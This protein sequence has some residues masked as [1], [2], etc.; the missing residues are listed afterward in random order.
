MLTQIIFHPHN[1]ILAGCV[2]NDETYEKLW[3]VRQYCPSIDWMASLLLT[4]V[5]G[6]ALSQRSNTLDF[7]FFFLD[8]LN[9]SKHLD[10]TVLV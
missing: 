1:G 3:W 2:S 5:C 8:E 4:L 7:F 9:E 10:F 6:P